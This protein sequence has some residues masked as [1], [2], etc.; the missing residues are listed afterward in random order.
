MSTIQIRVSM[1]V[2]HTFICLKSKLAQVLCTVVH[3]QDFD[4]KHLWK[5][6]MTRTIFLMLSGK[7]MSSSQWIMGVFVETLQLHCCLS[8]EINHTVWGFQVLL[9]YSHMWTRPKF[10]VRAW[11]HHDHVISHMTHHYCLVHC[12]TQHCPIWS[13][14]WS[15]SF[16]I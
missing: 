3:Y 10:K 1:W 15:R 13:H 14:Q 2:I 16:R 4:L 7:A 11:L 12:K 9:C 6:I 5:C 8:T